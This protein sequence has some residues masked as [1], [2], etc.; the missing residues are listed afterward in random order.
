VYRLPSTPLVP[1]SALTSIEP[2]PPTILPM[3]VSRVPRKSWSSKF[4]LLPSLRWSGIGGAGVCG[5]VG[6]T[7]CRPERLR[8]TRKSAAC[9]QARAARWRVVV[10]H[11]R[12]CGRAGRLRVVDEKFELLLLLKG[13]VHLNLLFE[14]RIQV[15]LDDFSSANLLPKPVWRLELD[16]QARRRRARS[17]SR[18]LENRLTQP[19][20]AD[21]KPMCVNEWTGHR[22]SAA[23]VFKF[24]IAAAR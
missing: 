3:V 16:L 14:L 15:V 5:W 7:N 22:P 23:Q 21:G 13:V 17:V 18:R 20:R 24:E 9:A 19:L 4:L 10:E 6:G 8:A 1:V 2:R 12:A 11:G